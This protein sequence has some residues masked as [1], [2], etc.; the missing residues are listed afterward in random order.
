V[1]NP[2]REPA[3]LGVD[4]EGLTA[5]LASGVS[6]TAGGLHVAGFGYGICALAG[7]F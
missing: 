2:R 6:P 5:L 4:A 1:V 7:A 3:T